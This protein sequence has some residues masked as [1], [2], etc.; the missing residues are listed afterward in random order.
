MRRQDKQL[1]TRQL[2]DLQNKFREASAEVDKRQ[3]VLQQAREALQYTKD[4]AQALDKQVAAIG[5]N[6]GSATFELQ[7]SLEA[8]H[9]VLRSSDRQLNALEY[10]LKETTALAFQLGSLQSEITMFEFSS[11]GRVSEL[12]SMQ[13]WDDKL[14]QVKDS[15]EVAADIAAHEQVK[16]MEQI[17]ALEDKLGQLQQILPSVIT[18]AQNA[19]DGIEAIAEK[20]IS[21]QQGETTQKSSVDPSLQARIHE[22][23]KVV[24]QQPQDDLNLETSFSCVDGN[25]DLDLFVDVDQKKSCI[26][27]NLYRTREGWSVFVVENSGNWTNA[28]KL[29]R[30]FTHSR[31]VVALAP[32]TIETF[33]N[34]SLLQDKVFQNRKL[35]HHR[36]FPDLTLFYVFGCSGN[37]GHALWDD[38][39][40]AYVSLAKFGLENERFRS[41]VEEYPGDCS[42]CLYQFGDDFQHFPLRKQYDRNVVG[43][44]VNVRLGNR[45]EI[46]VVVNEHASDLTSDAAELLQDWLSPLGISWREAIFLQSDSSRQTS[47]IRV[48]ASGGELVMRVPSNW[49]KEW[50]ERCGN[51]AIDVA[52]AFAGKRPETPAQ[53]VLRYEIDHNVTGDYFLSFSRIVMGNVG[54]ANMVFSPDAYT[55]WS[56]APHMLTQ[57]FR[58]RM[59]EAYGVER[60]QEA[61]ANSSIIFVLNKRD[62]LDDLAKIK[63]LISTLQSNHSIGNMRIVDWSKYNSFKEHLQICADADIYI[64]GPGTGM[65][66]APFL[67]D[68]AVVINTGSWI[69]V[70]PGVAMPM[71]METQTVGGSTPYL[72]VIF[73]NFS[74]GSPA[75]HAMPKTVSCSQCDLPSSP[76][77]EEFVDYVLQARKLLSERATFSPQDAPLKDNLPLEVQAWQEICSA[78]ITRCKQLIRARNYGPCQTMP[79]SWF[80]LLVYRAELGGDVCRVDAEV[81]KKARLKYGL[82]DYRSG[83]V[84]SLLEHEKQ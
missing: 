81:A 58:N 33:Q 63:Q 26:F 76:V 75:F 59:Q 23:E 13:I 29:G 2:Q 73:R 22:L 69:Q 52:A 62:T 84:L 21:Q 45:S 64:S 60:S 7:H 42:F 55:E 9:E 82:P 51:R 39:Y 4:R 16:A 74:Y 53:M 71:F 68:G 49:L 41:Y 20:P 79:E 32:I 37:I 83:G 56:R 31:S 30:V 44:L 54:S 48:N 72:R 40:P 43:D 36:H 15:S 8:M 19:E 35:F 17:K 27:S 65:M 24:Y 78:D 47:T 28:Q 14:K 12:Q 57:K 70:P 1:E 61:S 18:A 34:Y 11:F 80:E 5:R 66:N 50:H 38:L 77:V 25:S 6:S 10:G 67:S 3:V 46:Q